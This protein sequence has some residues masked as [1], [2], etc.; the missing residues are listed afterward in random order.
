VV[1][2]DAP[3]AEGGGRGGQCAAGVRVATG[4]VIAIVH[5]DARVNHPLFSQA[6]HVLSQDATLIGGAFGSVFAGTGVPLGLLE[7]ANDLR[8]AFLGIPFGD[9]VQFFRREPIVQRDAYPAI[10]LMEDVE[11]AARLR[12]LGRTTYL[13]G[14]V[15]ASARAWQS[16]RLKRA[17]L[18]IRLVTGY[19]WHRRWGRADPLA[20]YRRYYGRG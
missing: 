11:L 1:V 5:A 9:Q 4:D 8:A 15:H 13:F 10:P 3:P 17:V 19:L 20:M 7:F 18:I 16:D 14:D 6:L 2:H 12:E